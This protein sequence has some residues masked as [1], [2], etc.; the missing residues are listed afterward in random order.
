VP[1]DVGI[2]EAG[3]AVQTARDPEGDHVGDTTEMT[4]VF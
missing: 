1:D 4:Q 3:E 2:D